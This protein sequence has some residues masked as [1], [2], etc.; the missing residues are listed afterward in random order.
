MYREKKI[1]AVLIKIFSRR[2]KWIL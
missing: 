1:G 2:K